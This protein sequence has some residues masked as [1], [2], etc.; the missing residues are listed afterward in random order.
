[1][2]HATTV[3]TR[4][5]TAYAILVTVECLQAQDLQQQAEIAAEPKQQAAYR[6]TQKM[7]QRGQRSTSTPC[8]PRQS[9]ADFCI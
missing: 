9:S 5:S 1:M 4:S 7:Q 3:V 8:C 6:G 2:S